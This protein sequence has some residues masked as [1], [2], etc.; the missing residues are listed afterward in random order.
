MIALIIVLIRHKAI[1]S[2]KDSFHLLFRQDNILKSFLITGIFCA[3]ALCFAIVEGAPTGSPLYMLFFSL[4]VMIIGGGVEEIGW[5][6][7]LQPEMEKIFPFP[8]AT[9]FV[10]I[11]V[12]VWHLPLWIF[13]TSN[14][15]NDSLIGFAIMIFVWAF[16]G[17]AIYKSTKST[18]ACVMYHAFINAIG[19]VYDWNSLFDAYP[20]TIHMW[21]YFVV[22]F[23]GAIVLWIISDKGKKYEDH[24]KQLY[25]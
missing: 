12:Y 18:F 2:A 7:F 25:H 11:I 9:F 17:A 13:P 14:H 4:P 1:H 21:I 5:R 19:S 6:G 16:V 23:V 20:K 10:S 22:I 24:N 8:L 15:Y 3:A